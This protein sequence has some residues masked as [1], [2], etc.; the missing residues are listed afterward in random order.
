MVKA[1]ISLAAAK[2]ASC[3]VVV[4]LTKVNSCFTVKE[5]QHNN[6]KKTYFGFYPN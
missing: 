4:I 2:L 6:R 3:L 1:N 5:E